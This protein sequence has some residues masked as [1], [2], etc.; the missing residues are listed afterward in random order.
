[1]FKDNSGVK[2]I[3]K[4]RLLEKQERIEELAQMISGTPISPTAIAAAE[5][6]LES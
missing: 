4:I 2:T 1:M 5:E 6:M 3:S